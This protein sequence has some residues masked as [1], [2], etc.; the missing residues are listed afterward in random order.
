MA[1]FKIYTVSQVITV[2]NCDTI[3]EAIKEVGLDPAVIFKTE[4]V[5]E[6]SEEYL[7]EIRKMKNVKSIKYPDGSEGGLNGN[8]LLIP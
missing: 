5:K 4:E 8:F 3:E 1:V 2:N 7:Q 6:P